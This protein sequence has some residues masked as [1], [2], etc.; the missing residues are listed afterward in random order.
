M[1]NWFAHSNWPESAHVGAGGRL[2]CFLASLAASGG[3]ASAQSVAAGAVGEPATTLSPRT[4]VVIPFANI[5]GR[6]ADDW[7]GTGIVDVQSI[8]P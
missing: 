2:L 5:S 7:I 8:E 4:V 1:R 6:P 3:V